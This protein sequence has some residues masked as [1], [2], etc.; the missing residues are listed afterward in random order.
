MALVGRELINARDNDK[1][2]I[3]IKMNIKLISGKH[4]LI[5]ANVHCT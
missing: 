1:R 4:K 5:I 2:I 3:V